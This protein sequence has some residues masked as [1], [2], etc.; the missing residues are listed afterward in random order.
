V[1]APSECIEESE[2]MLLRRSKPFLRA[3]V[4]D[5][6][7]NRKSVDAVRSGEACVEGGS[8]G[9]S[10]TGASLGTTFTMRVSDAISG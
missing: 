7:R 9:R 8:A 6:P 4:G 10:V 5:F 2:R 1:A 3:V